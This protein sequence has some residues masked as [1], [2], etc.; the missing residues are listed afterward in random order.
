MK[1][2]LFLLKNALGPR[3]KRFYIFFVIPLRGHFRH[4]T[5][6]PIL[7]LFFC[8]FTC[9]QQQIYL[10][11]TEKINDF[12]N[13]HY[14]LLFIIF[15]SLMKTKSCPKRSLKSFENHR[16]LTTAAPQPGLDLT[17][18]F[19]K[20]QDNIK[21]GLPPETWTQKNSLDI[22]QMRRPSSRPRKRKAK[23][24]E[25]EAREKPWAGRTGNARC[26]L[27]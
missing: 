4:T 10:S 6:A 16:A 14:A 3:Y 1:V 23:Q 9:N 7:I 21:Q 25:V 8:F 18:S 19:P 15:Q 2:P 5:P 26:K 13:F 27:V 20:S 12:L 17:L 22:A 11:T 24:P